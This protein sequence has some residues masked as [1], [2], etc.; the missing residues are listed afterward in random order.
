MQ[1][2]EYTRDDANV[3]H[4]D[5]L[6]IGEILVDLISDAEGGSLIEARTFT[7]Y[8]GGQA[9]N[10]ALNISRLGG[11][12]SL[13]ARVGDDAFGSFLC[14]HLFTAG[15]GTNYIRTTSGIP[16]TLVTVSRNNATPD[17][18]VYRGADAQMVPDDMPHS[19]LAH[20][21]LVHTS[22]FALSREPT[23]STVINFVAQAYEAGCLVS[24]DPNYHP[25]L[26][27]ENVD[28]LSIFAQIY[29]YVFLT[30]PSL[31]DCVRLFGVGH[32][33]EAYAAQILALGAKNVVLTMGNAGVL[34]AN[35]RSL[36]ASEA[37]IAIGAGALD[38]CAADRAAVFVHQPDGTVICPWSL[39]LSGEFVA[40]TLAPVRILRSQGH[41]AAASKR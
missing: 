32:T 39:G 7:M 19:L 6:S 14:H 26:W 33:P 16:T 24:F 37:V 23:R 1:K 15:V 35:D 11:S 22:A 31:D 36:V 21:A 41:A 9:A 40:E 25:R 2:E 17:F 34:L 13:I 18:V 3:K 12:V 30:K 10:V 4:I 8:P 20:T 38:L 28:P 5:V 27:E 29:P